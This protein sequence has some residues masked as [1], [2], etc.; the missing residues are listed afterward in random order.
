MWFWKPFIRSEIVKEK[1]NTNTPDLPG[2][3]ILLAVVLS[4]EF[5]RPSYPLGIINDLF[6]QGIV[7]VFAIVFQYLFLEPYLANQFRF[8]A[9]FCARIRAWMA[10]QAPQDAALSIAHAVTKQRQP[11]NIHTSWHFENKNSIRI[12]AVT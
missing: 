3:R 6:T 11:G 5:I 1:L 2:C 12:L 4:G 7:T 9:A 10:I 8:T